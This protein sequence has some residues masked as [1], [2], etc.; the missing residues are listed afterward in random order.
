MEIKNNHFN[1]K[2]NFS[3]VGNFSMNQYSYLI[4]KTKKINE[5]F[6]NK[7]KS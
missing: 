5:Q 4:D 1:D 6:L 2:F 3:K 7:K